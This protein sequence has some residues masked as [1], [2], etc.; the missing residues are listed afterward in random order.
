VRSVVI[1]ALGVVV[2]VLAVLVLVAVVRR[3][4]L[5]HGPSRRAHVPVVIGL[6]AVAVAAVLQAP[7]ELLEAQSLVA[8]LNSGVMQAVTQF[9]LPVAFV[10]GA[11]RL[12]LT[13]AAVTGTLLELGPLPSPAALELALRRRLGDETLQV[14]RWSPALEDFVDRDGRVVSTDDDGDVVVSALEREGRLVA[15][16][17]QDPVLW[18]A[19]AGAVQVALESDAV[20]AELIA[21]DPSAADLPTGEVTFLFVDIEGSTLLL[22]QLGERYADL[23]STFRQCAREST[24]V[25]GGVVVDARGD[26]VFASFSAATSAVHAAADLQHRLEATA[27]PEGV[28]VWARMGLHTGRPTVTREG[29]VGADVHRAARVMAAAAGGQVLVSEAVVQAVGEGRVET[30]PLGRFLLRGLAQPSELFQLVMPGLPAR[31][32]AEPRAR[33]A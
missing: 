28:A 24:T 8:V 16:V 31:S 7:L 4:R 25:H 5:L 12:R 3:H 21:H 29:Y 14:L 10:L 23:L 33:R 1:A 17:L 15:G 19:V 22:E 20:R 11:L 30:V 9:A 6:P 2:A 18:K 27:W 26:E 32:F 13:R